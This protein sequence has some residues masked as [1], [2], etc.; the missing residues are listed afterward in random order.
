MAT[1]EQAAKVARWLNE[2]S[3]AQEAVQLLAAWAVQGPNDA[4][5]Q[6]LL[7]EALRIDPSAKVAQ[8]AFERMEGVVGE[9]Q[10]DL[11]AAIALFSVTEIER[12]EK[13]MRRPGF[14]RAQVGFNNNIKYRGL[15]FHVQTEDSGLDKP[16]II[17]HLFADGGRII[18][19]HKR[20]YTEEVSRSDV[21]IFVRGLMKS[22]HMEMAIMLRE[23]R[24]DP[25]IDG[26]AIGGMELL[27]EPPR[28]EVQ[29][30]AT[31]KDTRA[32]A[33]AQQRTP[34]IAPPPMAAP[35]SALSKPRFRFN[36]T[37][38]LSG[39][40]VVYEPPGDAA[41]LGREGAINLPG[42]VFCHPREAQVRYE[43]E[44]VWLQDLQEGN[45]VFLRIKGPTELEIGDEFIVGDQLLAVERNP[46]ADDAPDPHPTYFYSS[47]KWPSSFRVVQL[48]QGGAKGACVVA[49]GTSMMF[50]S[51]MG[52]FLFA[53]DPLVSEQ[54]CLV[55]EQAG[56]IIL[57]DLESRSGVFVRIKGEQ[58]LVKGDEIMVGR[59]RLMLDAIL[60]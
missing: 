58:E 3:R 28:T 9:A 56:A 11:D 54:H 19:S 13:E 14:F 34:S 43:S 44:H 1:R 53:D 49:R 51:M 35:V 48:F 46:V 26:K 21:A 39:G 38:S 15:V 16:H 33:G 6:S 22:Q 24:F 18:K 5:G 29:K 12:L 32:E 8:Q 10:Q 42:E 55:E 50:G 36:V 4:E 60:P 52:D 57:T 23:G 40:P 31:Q 30:L 47:P 37:R 20:T 25:V 17:T 2:K 41:I 59:T 7:A 27:L 45:G